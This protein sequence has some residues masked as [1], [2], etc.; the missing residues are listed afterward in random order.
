VRATDL[1]CASLLFVF[2]FIVVLLCF[3]LLFSRLIFI[4]INIKGVTALG[5]FDTKTNLFTCAVYLQHQQ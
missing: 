2:V 1:R 4:I 3:V 5:H